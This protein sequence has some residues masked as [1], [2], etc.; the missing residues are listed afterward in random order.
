MPAP[1][2]TTSVGGMSAT[3][4]SACG[5]RARISLDAPYRGGDTGAVPAPVYVIT[6]V[7]AAGKSTVAEALAARFPRSVH[8]HGDQFRRW[9]V[10]GREDPAPGASDEAWAQLAL[11]HRLT[12]DVA[13]TY[14]DAGFTVVVQDVILGDHLPAMVAAVGEP[15]HVVVLDPAPDAIAAREAARAKDS[16]GVWTIT[17]LVDGLRRDTPRLGLW[18]D[19]STLTVEQTVDAILDGCPAP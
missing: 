10:G 19:T 8:V 3:V 17:A 7:Q 9:V 4:R 11:R 12:A 2:T 13:R 14:R 16:Y 5:C 15:V 1:T 18:L 6:G